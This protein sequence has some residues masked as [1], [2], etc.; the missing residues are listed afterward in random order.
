MPPRPPSSS[1]LQPPVFP[2]EEEP[3]GFVSPLDWESPVSNGLVDISMSPHIHW[4]G[5]HP[6]Q[7]AR[8]TL[9]CP[10]PSLDLGSP[11]P[12]GSTDVNMSPT[13]AK[14]FNDTVPHSSPLDTPPCVP[15]LGRSAYSPEDTSDN[16]LLLAGLQKVDMLAKTH[17]FLPNVVLGVFKA[18]GD[19]EETEATLK[20]M[21]NAEDCAPTFIRSARSPEDT[22]DNT[23]VLAGLQKVD[24]LAKTH[25]FLPNVVLGVF[26]ASG[27]LEETEATLKAMANAEDTGDAVLCIN[28]AAGRDTFI[29]AVALHFAH[30]TT[31]TVRKRVGRYNYSHPITA[32]RISIPPISNDE[33]VNA[34][35]QSHLMSPAFSFT[36]PLRG[37]A[38]PWLG[39]D[40]NFPQLMSCSEC[41]GVDHYNEECPIFHSPAYRRAHGIPEPN[42]NA[43][44]VPNSL[45][46]DIATSNVPSSGG[47][48]TVRG[49]G[50]GHGF[51]GGRVGG[52]GRPFRGAGRGYGG[53]YKPYGY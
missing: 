10:H 15:T 44:N 42:I 39:P 27:D 18:S 23:L 19:L 48:T 9:A 51:R 36:V 26:K 33:D 12:N 3:S 29:L 35:I 16:T 38:I 52:G 40:A 4:T 8:W 11:V 2:P 30:I 53:G 32:H 47:W 21:A 22:S 37:V 24:M 46:L 17:G 28:V 45:T 5:D 34:R 6:F 14:A 13:G 31:C 1:P 7:T 49:T 43:S 50:R 20:A 41:H 25:G